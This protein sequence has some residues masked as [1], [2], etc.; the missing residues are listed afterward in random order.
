[1]VLEKKSEITRFQILVETAASQPQIKQSEIAASLGITPQAVSEYIK[2]LIEDGM[3]I[4]GGRGQY[5]VTPL[6]VETIIN[7]ARELQDY[8]KYV[9][10]NVVGPGE[11][12]AGHSRSPDKTGRQVSILTMRDGILY[13]GTGGEG[14]RRHC[15]L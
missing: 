4:S 3:I 6:G 1:M 2:S 11:R 7:G 5:K 13:A 9:L 10:N 8:S 15:H 14:A 12:L